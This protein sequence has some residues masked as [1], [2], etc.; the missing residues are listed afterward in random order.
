MI[1]SRRF[2]IL[3]C[4]LKVWQCSV[5]VWMSGSN[6][7]FKFFLSA[8]ILP[9]NRICGQWFFVVWFHCLFVPCDTNVENSSSMN[10][11]ELSLPDC[12]MTTAPL[13]CWSILL[14]CYGKAAVSYFAVHF[15]IFNKRTQKKPFHRS[16]NTLK[17][18]YLFQISC[19]PQ[20][21][22]NSDL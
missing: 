9:S 7:F 14:Q 12:N 21:Y 4:Y 11:I 20:G 5:L 3:K 2:I 19:K 22:D 16:F 13:T 17:H 6:E 10:A 1:S 8:I 15:V 18:S